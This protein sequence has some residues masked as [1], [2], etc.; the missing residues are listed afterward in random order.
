MTSDRTYRKALSDEIAI[1]ELKKFKGSQFDPQVVEAF[2]K[3]YSSFPDSIRNHIDD[4]VVG[5]SLHRSDK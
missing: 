3:L 2:L 5:V 1:S 4:I